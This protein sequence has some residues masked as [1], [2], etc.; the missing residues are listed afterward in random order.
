[1]DEIEEYDAPDMTTKDARVPL[2][3]KITYIIFPIW[4]VI[5]LFLFWNG[6]DGSWFDRG[7]WHELQIAANTTFPNENR[8]MPNHPF[9]GDHW[10]DQSPQTPRGSSAAFLLP[11]AMDVE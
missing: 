3:L 10:G 6:N 1:M 4:G 5:W 11:Q 7:Y 2:F 8:N 9:W